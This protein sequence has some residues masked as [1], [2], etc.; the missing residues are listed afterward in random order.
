MQVALKALITHNLSRDPG[1]RW[2][3]T[4]ACAPG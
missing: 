3:M 2:E 1:D 4:F